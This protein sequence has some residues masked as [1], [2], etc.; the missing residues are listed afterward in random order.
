VKLVKRP[1]HLENF[2][3]LYCGKSLAVLKRWST[4]LQYC[5]A[6]YL[7]VNARRNK[8]IRAP[9]QTRPPMN[10]VALFVI[11]KST[12]NSKAHQQVTG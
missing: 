5:L 7:R 11:A 3:F 12:N 10:A 9:T 1:Q 4:E 6:I 8:S 2:I